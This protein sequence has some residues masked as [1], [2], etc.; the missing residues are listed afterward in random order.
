MKKIFLIM[1][2]TSNSAIAQ[3]TVLYGTPDSQIISSSAD[4]K[5]EIFTSNQ[6]SLLT[7]IYTIT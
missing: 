6:A 1:L 4:T 7:P 2:L 3:T 5:R